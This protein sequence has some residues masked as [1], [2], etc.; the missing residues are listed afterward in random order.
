MLSVDCD[1][2]EKIYDKSK[3]LGKVI[4]IDFLLLVFYVIVD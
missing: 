2:D 1:L 4:I 3:W